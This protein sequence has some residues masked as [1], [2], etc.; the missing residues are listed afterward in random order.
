[1]PRPRVLRVFRLVHPFPSIL[2]G[3]VVGLVALVAGGSVL[4]SLLLGVSM[5]LLQFAIGTLNDI[6]DA[7]RDA[8][9][10]PG[11]PL[12]EGVVSLG[13]ARLVLGLTAAGGLSL[14]LLAGPGL[15]AI[16]IVVLAIGTA[17][18]LWA[19]GTRLSWL[20]LAVGIPLL[21]VYG[22]FGATGDLPAAFLVIVPAAAIAGAALAI[23][24]ATVDVERDEA[25][26]SSSIALALGPARA[27]ALAL[28]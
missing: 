18:D 12:V 5:T 11:K 26:G 1:M 4:R 21:P 10:K 3:G 20:P 19:K 8:G 15:L 24:N 13:V 7:P 2:D 25:A 14:G 9:S 27:S 17:Y 28:G 23:A 22:W 6:V 16:G